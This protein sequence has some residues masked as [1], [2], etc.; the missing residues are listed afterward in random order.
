MRR[1]DLKLILIVV[2]AFLTVPAQAGAK[3]GLIEAIFEIEREEGA[4]STELYQPLQELGM[5]LL[6]N[7][8]HELALDTFR[9][10]QHIIHRSYGVYAPEQLETVDLI[11][12]TYARMGEF[13]EVDTQQHFS[14][15]IAE[16]AF[17]PGDIRMAQANAK[18]AR[19]YRNTARFDQALDLYHQ[20]LGILDDSRVKFRVAMLRGEALTLYLSGRCCASDKLAEA[21]AI[22]QASSAFDFQEKRQAALDLADMLMVEKAYEAAPPAYALV[23]QLSNEALGAAMLGV[24][25][26]RAI[27]NAIVDATMAFSG[28][29]KVI[30]L[31]SEGTQ[32]FARTTRL[33]ASIGNPVP[34]CSATVEEVLRSASIERLG[35]Y[36]IDVDV[37]IDANGRPRNIETDGNA[38]VSL[39]RYVRAV[40]QQTR[41]RPQT[42]EDGERSAAKLSFRQTFSP[43]D[44]VE[45]V[46]SMN[47]W[48]ALLTKQACQ[49]VQQHGFTVMNAAAD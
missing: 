30:D 19:W 6:E 15:A 9:R 23:R 31:P 12:T 1:N 35:E 2:A 47:G 21:S 10:M 13:E 29:R 45:L 48:N 20:A 4:H 28:R 7:G 5:T 43:D 18:L 46:D 3:G 22:A 17:E 40:L 41:Y 32:L 34:V 27:S 11:T 16:R 26:P 24:R 38:P 33:P 39:N 25:H 49:T 8:E 36:F 37:E 42:T 44:G 14:F